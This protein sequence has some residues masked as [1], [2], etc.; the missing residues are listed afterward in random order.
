MHQI[1]TIQ[2]TMLAA[3]SLASSSLANAQQAPSVPPNPPPTSPG[4]NASQAAA[5][6]RINA[7]Q[8]QLH[9]TGAQIPQWTAFTQTMRDNAAHTDALFRQRVGA[10]TTMTAL[11]DRI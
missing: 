2:L 10:V 4:A 6:Q 7:L 5:D 11:V 1:S 3:L 9:I 8:A